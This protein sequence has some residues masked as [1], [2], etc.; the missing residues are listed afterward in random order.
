MKQASLS[1]QGLAQDIPCFGHSEKKD[2]P[3]DFINTIRSILPCKKVASG[4]NMWGKVA[5]TISCYRQ[6]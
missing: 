3:Q 2:P 1:I 4:Y 6:T 5:S